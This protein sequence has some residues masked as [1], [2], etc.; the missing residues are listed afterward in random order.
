M[1]GA[2]S[3]TPVIRPVRGGDIRALLDIYAPYV[4]SSAVSFEID[5]PSADAF[6]ARVERCRRGWA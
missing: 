4:E 2:H 1:P 3:I 6:A 5:V